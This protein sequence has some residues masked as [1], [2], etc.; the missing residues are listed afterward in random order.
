MRSSRSALC[1]LW[2]QEL[3]K[4]GKMWTRRAFLQQQG[5]GQR[6]EKRAA[7]RQNQSRAGGGLGAWAPRGTPEPE[8]RAAWR[9]RSR[10]RPGR[11][12]E[13][14]PR[15]QPSLRS[16]P[17]LPALPALRERRGGEARGKGRTLVCSLNASQSLKLSSSSLEPLFSLLF[18][19]DQPLVVVLL[20]QSPGSSRP[21]EP[22]LPVTELSARRADMLGKAKGTGGRQ[23]QREA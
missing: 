12:P 1:W 18:P 6:E 15:P 14:P 16:A 9:A 17:A 5:A 21:R 20:Q 10:E 2:S 7:Q 22:S 23:Q 3:G 4:T 8:L 11:A 19:S 13:L